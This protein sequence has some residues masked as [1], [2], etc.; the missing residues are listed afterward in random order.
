MGLRQRLPVQTNTRWYTTTS[1]ER[2]FAFSG[3]EKR[4]SQNIF[5]VR[6]KPCPRFAR[7]DNTETII[8]ENIM[9]LSHEEKLLVQEALQVYLHIVARQAPR[10]QVK[11]MASMA[12]EIID[13]LEKV[14]AGGGKNPKPHGITDEWFK[15]VCRT[16][17]KLTSSGC[18]E[19]VTEKYPGKCDPILH[20]EASKRKR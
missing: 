8:P 4:N 17:D 9:S 6:G 13:K 11:Q 10:D 3:T 2:L 1:R 5:F 12:K 14:G 7:K 15:N 20:Y 19:K 18:S 16:C